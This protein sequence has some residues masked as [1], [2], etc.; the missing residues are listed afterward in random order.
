MLKIFSLHPPRAR[1]PTR[2]CKHVWFCT[3]LGGCLPA[4]AT[5]VRLRRYTGQVW[6]WVDCTALNERHF[7]SHINFKLNRVAA[8]TEWRQLLSA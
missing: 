1:T 7:Y 4:E 8:L 2:R 3:R 5:L 6:G